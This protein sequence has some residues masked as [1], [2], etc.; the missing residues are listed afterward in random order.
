MRKSIRSV[1]SN[2]FNFVH[3]DSSCCR[4]KVSRAAGRRAVGSVFCSPFIKCTLTS[5]LRCY[6]RDY[7]VIRLYR[8]ETTSIHLPGLTKNSPTLTR[9][10]TQLYHRAVMLKPQSVTSPRLT[11]Q[12]WFLL[13]NLDKFILAWQIFSIYQDLIHLENFTSARQFRRSTRTGKNH[14][15]NYL[16]L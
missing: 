9:T 1:L 6:Y 4:D 13:R 14:S 8:D 11:W 15:N 12:H 2:L 5:K 3:L 7:Y 10:A 16:K